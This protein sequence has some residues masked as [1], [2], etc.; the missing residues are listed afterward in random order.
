[1]T[2]GSTVQFPVSLKGNLTRSVNKTLDGVEVTVVDEEEDTASDFKLPLEFGL[3][4]SARI[5]KSFVLSADYKRNFWDATNQSEN[6]GTYT[7]QS[8]YAIG[9]EFSKND[10]GFNYW[11][12]MKFRAGFNYDDGYIAINNQKIDG[13]TLTTGLGI[14]I[15][16]TSNS[17]INLSYSY[18]SKGRIQNILV[19]ENYHT[20]TLNFSLEDLWFRKRRIN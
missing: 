5:M 9:V 7:D 19:K 8:I 10:R 12:R 3:G 13:Y 15:G 6:I 16:K 4:F 18:G 1:M 14:P 11:E 20:L 17:I 2:F